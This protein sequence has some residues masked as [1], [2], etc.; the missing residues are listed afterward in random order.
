MPYVANKAIE[1]ILL[2]ELLRL[3]LGVEHDTFITRN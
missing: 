3:S 1:T 2:Q